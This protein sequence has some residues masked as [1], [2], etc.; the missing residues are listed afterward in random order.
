MRRNRYFLFFFFLTV[1]DCVAGVGS[2]VAGCVLGADREAVLA[3]LDLE[4]VRGACR[5]RS[6]PSSSLHWKLEPGSVELKLNVALPFFSFFFGPA[7]IVV[8]GAAVSPA[9][10]PG[11][12]DRGDARVRRR[13]DRDPQVEKWPVTPVKRTA[14]GVPV[15]G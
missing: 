13:H 14:A 5:P 3:L 10:A 4:A 9:G 15:V 1:H 11:L 8:S 2:D 12:G 6:R 7:V